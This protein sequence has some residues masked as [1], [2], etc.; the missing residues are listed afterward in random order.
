[1]RP[2]RVSNRK[3]KRIADGEDKKP[4][5]DLIVFPEVAVHIDDQDIIKRLADKTNS[6]IFAGLV[7]TDHNDIACKVSMKTTPFLYWRFVYFTSVIT[8][9]S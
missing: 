3:A 2:Y 5:A 9:R 1:M 7:F 4:S 6:I 8:V